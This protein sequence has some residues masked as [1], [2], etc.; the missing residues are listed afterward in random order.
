MD[1]G[2]GDGVAT[3]L[4]RAAHAAATA[5]DRL[6]GAIA[7][8][9]LDDAVRLDDRTRLRVR[10]VLA[11]LAGEVE[12]VLR[13]QAARLLTL[14]DAASLAERL[15]TNGTPV[16][17]RLNASGLLRDPALIREVIGRVQQDAIADAL[18]SHA[19]EDRDRPS[20][21]PRLLYHADSSVS[22]AAAA[23]LAAESRRRGVA[24]VGAGGSSDLPADLHRHLVWWSAAA[25]RIGIGQV[26]AGAV[27]ALDRALAE[28]AL[29]AIDAHVDGDR[30]DAVAMRLARA[31][32]PSSSERARWLI[33]ALRDRRLSLFIA[34]LADG[35][36]LSYADMRAI[37]L[38]PSGVRLWL[39]LRALGLDRAA[40]ARVGL[41]LAEADPRRDIDG[42]V[43]VLDA[44]MATDGAVARQAL[45]PLLLHRDYRAALTAL[46]RGMDGAWPSW[47]LPG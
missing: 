2:A 1:R 18:P 38:D 17:A 45:A 3:L 19:P 7:D 9:F 20:L 15:I 34:L 37:V 40:I 41:A 32:D 24:P 44:I 27:P 29:H 16:F 13:V 14:R 8:V 6:G 12:T 4:A 5:E 22:A 31:L 11:Q 35:L 23:L 33:E 25:L 39:V 42:F 43:A 30:L 47:D 21:L 10:A 26:G 28:A 36:G 46:A